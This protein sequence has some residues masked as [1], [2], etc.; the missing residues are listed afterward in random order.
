MEYGKQQRAD[1]GCRN[2][3]FILVLF[4]L[5]F[6]FLFHVFYADYKKKGYNTFWLRW[7]LQYIIAPTSLIGCGEVRT[8]SI[9]ALGFN[10]S[11][12]QKRDISQ[13]FRQTFNAAQP[14]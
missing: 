4:L 11:F 14:H 5:F 6:G 7:I 8:A 12:G 2:N 9:E 10:I 13:R 1:L 3:A